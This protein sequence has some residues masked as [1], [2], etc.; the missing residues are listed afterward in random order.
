MKGCKHLKGNK[1]CPQQKNLKKPTTGITY[2][3]G[4]KALWAAA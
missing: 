3:C 2:P 4:A 1:K